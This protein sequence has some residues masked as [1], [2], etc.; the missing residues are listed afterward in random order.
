MAI[1]TAPLDMSAE[2]TN[3]TIIQLRWLT[4]ESDGGDTITGYFIERNLNGAG[5][6]VLVADTGNAL[7]AFEDSTLTA[8]DNAVYRVS[9][10]NISG[11][12]PTSDTDSTT[13]ATSEAETIRDLLFNNWALTGEL[14]KTSVSG[15]MNEAVQFFDRGQIPGNKKAK[16]VVVQK[17]NELGNESIVEH[18]KFF[19]QSDTFE[20]SCFLQVPDGADDRFSVFIDLMQQMTGEVVRILK[21]IFS[22]STDTG[23][24]FRTNTTW[25]RDNTF[26]PDDPTLVRTLRFTL[27]RI[28]ATSTEV[29]LGFGGILV[30]D[31]SASS[32][33]S[34]PTSDYIYT[35]VQ[36]VQVVQGWRNIPYLTT[37]SPFTTAIPTYFR[38]AFAGQFSC[39]MF[40]K[41]ADILPGTFNA[42]NQLFL[43]QDTGELGTAT[44]L[45]INS[46]TEDTVIQLTE[47]VPVN[48]TSIDKISETEELVKFFLR[49]NLTQPSTYSTSI[50]GDMLY[51]DLSIMDYE[52]N[53]AMQ[54]EG[55]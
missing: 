2:A 34:L 7:V 6:A 53:V 33:D 37:D 41:K 19:E 22:P 25:T 39:Q 8:R 36:R 55:S 47:S 45:Q 52:D 35:E 5:F 14:S 43:P 18:P 13:T 29:F 31:T 40:L 42:L 38:G 48:I 1:P 50:A 3:P 21:T 4:P 23:E 46:N 30:F 51:E 10:I 32:A 17:I 26:T 49:G 15:A 24:F 44:F 16:A 11:T 28:V 27:T 54:Y 20:V 12:G 9:A